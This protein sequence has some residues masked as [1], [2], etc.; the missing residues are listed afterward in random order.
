MGPWWRGW[1][2]SS[3]H[4]LGF[5]LIALRLELLQVCANAGQARVLT[6]PLPA[7]ANVVEL[8]LAALALLRPRA[9]VEAEQCAPAALA[10]S[11]SA[12]LSVAQKYPY[13]NLDHYYVYTVVL[14]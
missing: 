7:W 4:L 11:A 5:M 12:R 9:V 14:V 8:L 2:G 1:R 13:G 10:S 3:E 6:L